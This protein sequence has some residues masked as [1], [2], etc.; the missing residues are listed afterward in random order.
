MNN[1]EL[2]IVV[3][4]MAALATWKVI[5]IVQYLAAAACR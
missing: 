5:E 3:M 4:I 2:I 1:F